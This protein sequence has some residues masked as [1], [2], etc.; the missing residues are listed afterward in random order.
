V[1]K[2]YAPRGRPWR[3]RH[4]YNL[5]YATR[6]AAPRDRLLIKAQKIREMLGGSPA[7]FDAFPP[8]PKGMHWRR[9]RRLRNV[10]DQ[11]AD[12]CLAMLAV[13]VNRLAREGR[14]G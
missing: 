13:H 5:T 3:C 1:R 2:L 14:R 8:R 10:H 11:A 4:C 6:Q 7:I 9:Y 12:N